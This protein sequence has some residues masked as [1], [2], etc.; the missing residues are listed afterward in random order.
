MIHDICV[1]I[2]QYSSPSV[3]EILVANKEFT[4]CNSHKCFDEFADLNIQTSSSNT[5]VLYMVATFLM[6]MYRFVHK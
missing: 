2:Q 3:E 4:L 6:L 5:P 1:Y